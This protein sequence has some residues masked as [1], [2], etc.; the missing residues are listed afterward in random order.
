L[1]TAEPI[2]ISSAPSGRTPVRTNDAVVDQAPIGVGPLA[3]LARSGWQEPFC[4][5][6]VL[7]ARMRMAMST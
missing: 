6:Q 7:V 4:C 5:A 2:S 3:D 1:V